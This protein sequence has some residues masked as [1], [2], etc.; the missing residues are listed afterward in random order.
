MK[1]KK[2]EFSFGCAVMYGG[3]FVSGVVLIAGVFS[4]FGGI[5]GDRS[6]RVS[7]E[8][9]QIVATESL[10]VQISA[11][12]NLI[13]RVGPEQAQEE[14]YRSGITFDGQ[15]HLLN[16]TAGDWLY[17]EYGVEGL[18]YC[19]D[20][21]LSSCYHGFVLNA[22]ARD[23]SD[24]MIGSMMES[25]RAA[26]EARVAP[27]CAHAIGHGLL[28]WYGYAN[29]L[30]ALSRCDQISDALPGFPLFNCH[31]GIFM[32]NIWGVHSG[33]PDPNRWVKQG[34]LVY[35]CDDPRIGEEYLRACWSNQPSLAFQFTQGSI[36]K[37][38][39][40]C[41]AV[42]VGE[43]QYTC[44]DGLARQVQPLTDGSI[45]RVL[46]L[47]AEFPDAWESECLL[48]MSSSYFSLGDRVMPKEICEHMEGAPQ[49]RCFERMK[50][51]EQVYD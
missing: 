4:L 35:P 39:D 26:G 22:L 45:E 31:D 46:S 5:G 28:A 30:Q 2:A 51:L 11:Y 34:D 9:S 32:E 20:Y 29:L 47:C 15:S 43:L 37:V 27:Q 7:P 14:L 24:A 8:I 23:D 36:A 19:K 38:A 12:E 21:F 41:S 48:T 16:H 40:V 49:Q 13:E 1:F 33:E 44:F 17:K 6:M 3:A 10:E 25:C 42:E 18:V 50:N